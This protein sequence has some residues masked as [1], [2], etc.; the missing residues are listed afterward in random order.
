MYISE[1]TGGKA[2]YFVDSRKQDRAKTKKRRVQR[3]ERREQ[4]AERREQKGESSEERRKSRLPAAK[5]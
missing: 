5:K 1:I 2:E 3:A 4:R